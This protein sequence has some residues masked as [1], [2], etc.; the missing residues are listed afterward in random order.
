MAD[1]DA[2][3]LRRD[4]DRIKEAMGI[5]DRYESAPWKWL[6]FGSFVAVGSAFAQYAVLADLSIW[7]FVVV[8]LG[9]G[10]A[11][12]MFAGYSSSVFERPPPEKP[13]IP[14]QV[15]SPL[16]AAVP[17]GVVLMAF[18]PELDYEA[19]VA[20]S[21][22]VVLVLFGLG[23]LLAANSLRAYH[24]HENDRHVFAAA[25]LL[26]IGLAV[27]IGTFDVLHRWGYAALGATQLLYSVTAYAVLTRA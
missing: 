10:V 25:G 21:L 2:S 14:F 11:S 26:M 9:F 22:A 7:W 20:V 6:L 3:A 23:F 12:G 27:A 1:A 5:S 16:L 17:L 4:V 18:L 24:L 15:L 8:W 19:T 13:N